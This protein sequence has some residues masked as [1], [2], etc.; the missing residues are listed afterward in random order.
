MADAFSRLRTAARVQRS[1]TGFGVADYTNPANPLCRAS[2]TLAI[3]PA[4]VDETVARTM[5]VPMS[6]SDASA[7]RHDRFRYACKH[8]ELARH[9]ASVRS[10]RPARAA[11]TRQRP[12]RPAA[13]ISVQEDAGATKVAD[14][15]RD[16]G[17]TI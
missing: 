11:A 12:R 6:T 7:D 8:D 16:H 1:S 5:P 14:G 13:E 4:F 2:D 17:D 3:R 9:G 10:D 15:S